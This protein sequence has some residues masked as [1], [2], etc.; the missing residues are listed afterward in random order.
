MSGSVHFVGGRGTGA[1][2]VQNPAVIPLSVWQASKDLSD[3]MGVNGAPINAKTGVL[4]NGFTKT[5]TKTDIHIGVSIG[6]YVY[7]GGVSI[8]GTFEITDV[9]TDVL[10]F[11]GVGAAAEVVPTAFT[12]VGGAYDTHI[13]AAQQASL[14]A[15]IESQYILTS[16]DEPALSGTVA[17]PNG[18]LANIS[19]THLLGYDTVAP[20]ND[21][22]DD[23][24]RDIGGAHYGTYTVLDADGGAFPIITLFNTNA[25]IIRNV[26]GTNTN[27]AGGNS[28]IFGYNSTFDFLKGILI[29]NCKFTDCY[30]GIDFHQNFLPW[31]GVSIDSCICNDNARHGI[32][33][34][35]VAGG[36][37]N[38][39]TCNGNGVD[40]IYNYYAHNT[41]C[42]CINNTAAGI[43]AAVGSILFCTLADNN[44]GIETTGLTGFSLEMDSCII[45]KSTTQ[46]IKCNSSLIFGKA[47]CSS[48]N[49]GVDS[50]EYLGSKED[51]TDDPIFGD[52]RILLSGSPCLNTGSGG[53]SRGAQQQKQ[54]ARRRRIV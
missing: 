29:E 48:N 26:H 40:G 34:Q 12:N 21:T 9:S 31:E 35:S 28:G 43:S 22:M 45:D 20:S 36:I 44:Y 8:F 47:N 27:Q 18:V 46:N 39:C 49:G 14:S 38:K 25:I 24:D 50:S 19:I 3:F 5:L 10:T 17:L 32:Y 51:I 42:Q 23:G 33:L 30:D 2:G 37:T 41:F 54:G 13:H 52:N 6:D 1:G 15:A 4:Y 11:T 7:I 53:L 16:L